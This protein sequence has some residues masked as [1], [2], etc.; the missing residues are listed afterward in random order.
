MN[1]NHIEND[2][3]VEDEIRTGIQAGDNTGIMGSGY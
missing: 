2:K 1:D 3:E